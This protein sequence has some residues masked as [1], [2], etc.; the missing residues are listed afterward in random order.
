METDAT[1][2]AQLPDSDWVLPEPVQLASSH[3]PRYR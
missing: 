1:Q 3:R 2:A